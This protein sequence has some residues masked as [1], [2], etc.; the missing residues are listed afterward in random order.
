MSLIRFLSSYKSVWGGLIANT[1]CLLLVIVLLVGPLNNDDSYLNL[2]CESCGEG[3]EMSGVKVWELA[4]VL[5]VSFCCFMLLVTAKTTHP[6][7]VNALR[8]IKS[9]LIDPMKHLDNWSKGDPCTSN[10]AGV[11]CSTVGTDGYMHIEQ[12]QLLNMNLSGS[13][14]PE[15]GQLSNIKV[16]DL[17]WNNITGSIPKE[18]GNISTLQLLLL[19][20]N[21]LSGSLPDE[22]GHL[23]QLDRLQVDEN[24]LSGPIPKSFS[25]L[26]GT[27]H[28]HMS[29]NSFSGQIPPELS[30]LQKILHWV[31]DNN[32]LSGFLPSEFSNMPNLRILQL[33]N[34]HFDGAEIPAS[35]GKISNLFK[36]SLRNCSLRGSIPD[37]SGI[38]QLHYLDLSWNHLTGSIPSNRLSNSVTTIDLSNNR[39]IGSIPP[40]FS[41]LTE[42]QNMSLA[43]NMLSGSVSSTIWQ[44]MTFSLTARLMLDF[45]N[46]SFSNILGDHNPPANVS[47][48][49]EGNPF[50]ENA[51]QADIAYFCVNE[52]GGS[53]TN[54]NSIDQ[55]S[56][57]AVQGCPLDFYAYVPACPVQCFC[58]APLQID[59]RL[60]SPS[61]SYFPPY[62]HPFESY[63]ASSLKLE[64]FQIFINLTV[65]EPG[66]RLRMHLNIFPAPNSSHKFNI[67]HKFNTSEVLR[68]RRI[69]M[70]W[71]F[72]DNHIFG[73]YEVLSFTLLWPYSSVILE[74]QSSGITKGELVGIVLGLVGCVVSISGLFAIL[75]T[76]RRATCYH[77]LSRERALSR[78]SVKINGVKDFTLKEIAL[79]TDKFSD[80]SQVGQGGYGKVY[81]GILPDQTIVAIK[82]AQEGSLQGQK[83]FLTEIEILSRLHH[84]NLVS[85]L[86]YCDEEGEQ[87]LIYEFMPN[88]TLRDW[89]SA[90]SEDSLSFITRL[91]IA[92]GSAKGILYLHTEADPP[93][94]HRDI[95]ASN[96]LL[97]SKLNAKVSDFGLSRLAPVPNVEGAI[98]DQVSTVVKGTPG[99]LDPEYFLT[100]MLTAK[101]DVYSLG[102]VFLELLTGM[103]AIT[104]GKNIVREVKMAYKSG[105]V[106]TIIDNRMGSYP[107]KCME[108]FL[109]LA[110]RCCQDEIDERPSM[111]EVVRELEDILSM[112]LESDIILPDSTVTYSESSSS[113][114]YIRKHVSFDVS[115]SDLASNLSTAIPP[116]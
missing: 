100:Q 81:K 108:K 94:L 87:M 16:L 48:R 102:V 19:N 41:G 45:R 35:Y 31:L 2:T 61:F 13:L 22:I 42:L 105:I 38:K 67:P 23:P 34:N 79:A 12:L 39:L 92:L 80:S 96:I 11:S 110:L 62:E 43:N 64:L 33:D 26:N 106:L 51:S 107:S 9:S 113:S 4:S 18:I 103:Q 3:I 10:W 7:E 47:I 14:A 66:P 32:N 114:A 73:P 91:R 37:L 88:G 82:R 59:Y 116:R 69:F 68:I 24:Q 27:R 83:E 44:N 36:L 85:L 8:A 99:Y 1:L 75:I 50:C 98:P 70:T 104:L 109:A 63:L 72:L 25:N 78:I 58:A 74:S 90:K 55:S 84:R 56:V 60:K 49:L 111:S 17:M 101:S 46:N 5:I 77:N 76:R 89:I 93:I 52:V 15:I 28:L 6:S 112:T 71:E 40:N 95:K 21:K 57:C 29:N 65:W 30:K 86:G 115:G 20:G 97:D 53:N 54:D